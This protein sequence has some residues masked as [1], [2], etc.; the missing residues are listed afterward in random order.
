MVRPGGG[1]HTIAAPE[2]ATDTSSHQQLQAKQ[3][4]ELQAVTV[5]FRDYSSLKG[6]L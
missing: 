1:S 6:C 4:S 5:F 3:N 2:Y